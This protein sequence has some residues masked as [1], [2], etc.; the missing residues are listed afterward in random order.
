VLGEFPDSC[1]GLANQDLDVDTRVGF[2]LHGTSVAERLCKLSGW[3]QL[4]FSGFS[5]SGF[6]FAVA[7][8]TEMERVIV[9]EFG[10]EH[11]L[12]EVLEANGTGEAV[13]GEAAD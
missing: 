5:I 4:V 13:D 3:T 8:P 2:R 12:R 9:L 6:G 7:E 1:K 10:G 11:G